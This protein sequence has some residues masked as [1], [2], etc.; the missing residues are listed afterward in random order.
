M[1]R[2]DI[3]PLKME[4]IDQITATLF[5]STDLS[6]FATALLPPALVVATTPIARRRHA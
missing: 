3:T 5:L 4:D 2:L 6:V 1:N